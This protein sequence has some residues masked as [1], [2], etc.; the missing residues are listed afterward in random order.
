M[1]DNPL[2]KTVPPKVA[3]SRLH[4]EILLAYPFSTHILAIF[5]FAIAIFIGLALFFIEYTRKERVIGQ[6]TLDKGAVKIFS[7]SAI[8]VVV[9]AL[10]KEGDRVTAGQTLFV[11]S[12]E[13]FTQRGD[14][15][16]NLLKIIS[17]RQTHL[18]EERQKALL[19]LQQDERNLKERI[20]FGEQRFKHLESEARQ[21]QQEVDTQI[22]RQ[23][24]TQANLTRHKELLAQNFVSPIKIDD[25]E[26]ELLEQTARQQAIQRQETT[27]QKEATHQQSELSQWRG[28]LAKQ[29]LIRDNR[30]SE[31]D[32]QL[33]L[34][35]QELT[36]SE[37]R[38]ELFV[39]ASQAGQITTITATVG[40]VVQ[41]DRPLAVLLP[42]QSSLL[43]SIYLPSRAYG[44]VRP[45]L[46][47]LLRYPAYPYQKFGQY[48]GT[49]REVGRTALS[50]E[51][52]KATSLAGVQPYYRVVVNL[53][54]QTV[55]AY[56]KSVAL[57]EGLQ[58]EADI[59]IDTRKLYEWIL[60]PLYSVTGKL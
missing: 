7:P 14:M 32:R 4:G 47:V 59:L 50:A 51:D 10:V 3:P 19:S 40:Q 43:A 30:L 56:G 8:G 52:L 35:D 49:I 18:K 9:K 13:R 57:Q 5:S 26:Q 12:A 39:V 27:V 48:A 31:I 34:L 53:E 46:N 25:I 38:R 21:L 45:D 20:N 33:L 42:E 11:I 58:V 28:E 23:K 22:K 54:S 6:L 16:A 44:F 29:P 15:Q 41:S 60:E 55:Q 24:L 36:D 1:T 17:D 2:P 37:S